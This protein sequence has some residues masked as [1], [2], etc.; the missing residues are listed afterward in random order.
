MVVFVDGLE[1]EQ[2]FVYETY[3]RAVGDA[4]DIR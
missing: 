2:T 1:E 3:E 4:E